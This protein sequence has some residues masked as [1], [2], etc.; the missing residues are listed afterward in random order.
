MLAAIHQAAAPTADKLAHDR[1]V[2]RM[3][4]Q[5]AGAAVLP[6]MSQVVL[7]GGRC[8]VTLHSAPRAPRNSTP[9]KGISQQPSSSAG[10][11]AAAIDYEGE[12][13]ALLGELQRL[14]AHANTDKRWLVKVRV[15][16]RSMQDGLPGF[17]A[18]WNAWAARDELPVMTLVEGAGPFKAAG[19][20][21]DATALAAP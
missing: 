12:S 17:Q 7:A 9:G 18:A 10:A 6:A 1:Q 11:A 2:A 21:L 14:L 20:M 4:Y 13:A 19:V 16:L 3:P 15:T 5:G 8:Y